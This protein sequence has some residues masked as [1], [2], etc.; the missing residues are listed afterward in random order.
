MDAHTSVASSSFDSDFA[1]ATRRVKLK[2]A[3]DWYNSDRVK[4][5]ADQQ[6]IETLAWMRR[7]DRSFLAEGAEVREPWWPEPK[8]TNIVALKVRRQRQVLD[9]AYEHGILHFMLGLA[10]KDAVPRLGDQEIDLLL[11][12]MTPVVINHLAGYPLIGDKLFIALTKLRELFGNGKK[13][14]AAHIR[15]RRLIPL[16]RLGLLEGDESKDGYKIRIGYLGFV[17]CKEVFAPIVDETDVAFN[18]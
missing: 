3:K 13:T 12:A 1:Q 5:A 8:T 10:E 16:A 7:N 14:K 11:K 15:D 6:A 2:R 17:F 18:R 4:A 9:R